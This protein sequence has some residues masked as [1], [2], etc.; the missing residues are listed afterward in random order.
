MTGERAG[1]RD[2]TLPSWKAR[3]CAIN[4]QV[5]WV[6]WR[7][8]RSVLGRTGSL[9]GSIHCTGIQGEAGSSGSQGGAGN[10]G[11][12]Q[13][14]TS[15]LGDQGSAGSSGDHCGTGGAGDSE[16]TALEIQR[17]REAQGA[18]ETQGHVIQNF[19]WGF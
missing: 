17:A 13:G 3:P 8:A 14:G 16:G 18:S 7:L 19:L 15:S 2:S 1:D 5:G 11:G 4:I 6:P 12:H 10:S 9:Q